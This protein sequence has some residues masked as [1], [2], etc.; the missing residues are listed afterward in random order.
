MFVE[1]QTKYLVIKVGSPTNELFI[2]FEKA[3][4]FTLEFTLSWLLHVSV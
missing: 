1:N 3:L 4:E 2:R